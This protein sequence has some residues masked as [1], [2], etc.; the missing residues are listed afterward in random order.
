MTQAPKIPRQVSNHTVFV[1]RVAIFT[2]SLPQKKQHIA[3]LPSTEISF[4][5]FISELREANKNNNNHPPKPLMPGIW[6]F[7]SQGWVFFGSLLGRKWH[8]CLTKTPWVLV[9][10]FF[11]G[12]LLPQD[13]RKTRKAWW[14]FNVASPKAPRRV[15]SQVGGMI[16]L[17]EKKSWVGFWPLLTLWPENLQRALPLFFFFGGGPGLGDEMSFLFW[18]SAYFHGLFFAVSFRE[19]YVMF[20]FLHHINFCHVIKQMQNGCR[21]VRP[22]CP[23]IIGEVISTIQARRSGS[24]GWCHKP[25]P[26]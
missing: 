2:P 10:N 16:F 1:G 26:T 6:T 12:K 7:R 5:S 25:V 9:P 24:L 23:N 11:R 20:F 13:Q 22:T 4:P 15:A 19:W 21:S 8:R 17:A 18:D 14:S 3:P